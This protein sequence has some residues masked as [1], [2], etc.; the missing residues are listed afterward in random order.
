MPCWLRFGDTGIVSSYVSRLIILPCMN[1]LN[2]FSVHVLLTLCEV[3]ELRCGRFYLFIVNQVWCVELLFVLVCC[4]VLVF[5]SAAACYICNYCVVC[6]IN[7]DNTARCSFMFFELFSVKLQF[8]NFLPF[9][10]FLHFF[11]CLFVF[12]VYVFDLDYGDSS[13]SSVDGWLEQSFQ[14]LWRLEDAALHVCPWEQRDQVLHVISSWSGASFA[15]SSS[16]SF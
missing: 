2:Y 8:S 1:Y 10:N 16:S 4:F 14:F 13:D 5:I 7:Q 12:P 9:F 11:D 6:C 15:V 3:H